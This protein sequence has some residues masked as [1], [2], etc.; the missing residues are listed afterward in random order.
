MKRALPKMKAM[1]EERKGHL[2]FPFQELAQEIEVLRSIA[3]PLLGA[4]SIASLKQLSEDLEGIWSAAPDSQV[5]WQLKGLWTIVSEG[6]YE[7]PGR[8]GSRQVVACIDGTWDVRPIGANAKKQKER[9]KRLLEFCGVASTRIRL[10]DAADRTQQIAMWRME[11]GDARSP[12]CYFHVQVLGEDETSM[13]PKSVSVP[14]LPS[15]FVT[16]MG[17]IEF[18][19][20]ELFQEKWAKAA[21]ENSGNV[22][23]WVGFQKR[24]LLCL[25]EWQR[26]TVERSLMSPWIA[27]KQEK[28]EARLFLAS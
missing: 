5:N 3:S 24:R 25:L 22:Q 8:K 11:L 6:E 15:M 26:K 21:M 2:Q 7:P 23:R 4:Q 13:F 20:G 19:L 17:A 9:Q 1:P 16:P 14:R 10:F 18:V 12:G 27:L 28:P